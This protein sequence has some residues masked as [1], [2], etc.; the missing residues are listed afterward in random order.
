M[1][2]PWAEQ[3]ENAWGWLCGHALACLE[4]AACLPLMIAC[5]CT[6]LQCTM[7]NIVR[8]PTCKFLLKCFTDLAAGGCGA[9]LAA[10]A[11]PCL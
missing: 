1:V 2:L 5:S 6:C 4:S 3:Q 9:V 7:P 8:S 10:A 11:V